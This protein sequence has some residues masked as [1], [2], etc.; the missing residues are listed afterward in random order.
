MEISIITSNIPADFLSPLGVP[1]WDKRKQQYLQ[2][3]RDADPDVI[4]FQEVTPRQ[5]QYLQEQLPEFSLLS[6]PVIDPDPVLV[7][8]WQT[9]YAKYGLDQIPNPYELILFYRND[10]FE[11]FANGH[12]WLSPTPDRPSIGFGN[13]APRVVL[14]AHFHH[15]A[16]KR[17]F[18]IF[19][20]HIDHR[21]TRAM[22]GLFR[23]KFAS[24]YSCADGCIFMGDLNV[25]PNDVEYKLLIH[26]GWRDSHEAAPDT[27]STTFISNHPGIPGRR[28]DHILYHGDGLNPRMWNRLLSPETKRRISDH[29]P[30]HV[31]F[32]V[33]STKS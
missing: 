29:D 26:D 31:I 5:L 21:C 11:P 27:Q 2:V 32:N 24:F 28:I 9:N 7:T 18:L 6:V 19:N 15:F 1:T 16:S 25:N 20:T 4:G 14:W 8:T 13:I 17:H 22:L 3:V 33:T 30:V 12:W 23:E 10:L